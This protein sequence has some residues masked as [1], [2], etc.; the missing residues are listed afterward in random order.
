MR[1]ERRAEPPRRGRRS[2]AVETAASGRVRRTH[3]RPS[4]L[5][6]ALGHLEHAG[7]VRAARV[8]S[9]SRRLPG[10]RPPTTRSPA[11]ARPSR[12]GSGTPSRLP[13]RPRSRAGRRSPRGGHVLLHAP[14][15]SGKTLAAFLWCLD[16]LVRSPAP[17]PARGRRRGLGPDPL[18]QPAQGAHLRRGAQPPGAR[19]P[20]SRWP[21]ERL[22]SPVR[23]DLDRLADGRH[24]DRRAARSSRST[25]P[26]ILIT[27]PESLYLLLTS[28]AREILRGVEHVIVDEVHAVAGTKRG[29][30]LRP[31]PRAPGAPARRRAHRR[32]SGSASR[33]PSG[34][35]RRSGAS[36]PACGDGP[37][38]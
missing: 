17:P 37:R 9:P 21:A 28:Q 14:T 5:A 32:S 20:A 30:H 12:P 7:L 29:A 10:P 36:S 1:R 13:R 35:S 19:S 38:R 3:G 24:A 15:G 2:E 33:P 31:Q 34:R 16:R 6:R 25:P 18:R 27:T 23:A 26:E 11:S 4:P 8:Y 22:G